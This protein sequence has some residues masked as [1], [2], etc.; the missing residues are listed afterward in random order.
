MKY[1]VME[2]YTSYAILL[3]EEGRFVKAANMNY[4]VGQELENPVLMH[5]NVESP[6]KNILADVITVVASIAACI[7]IFF[8]FN[9]YRYYLQPYS[10]ITLSINPEVKIQVS[11]KGTVTGIKGMNEDGV[12]LIEG[13]N[14]KGK[15]KLTVTD[16]LIDRAIDMGYLYESG[17]IS[18]NIDAPDEITFEQYGVELRTNVEEHVSERITIIIEK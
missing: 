10:A 13:Y 2:C 1:L 8:G 3:D 6:L 12:D 7:L 4:Q 14:G 16:E 15:D 11:R 9:Y 18:F 5:E 17:Q